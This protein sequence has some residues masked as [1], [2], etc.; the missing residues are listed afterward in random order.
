M[1]VFNSPLELLGTDK[2]LSVHIL[3][4]EEIGGFGDFVAWANGMRKF[5]TVGQWHDHCNERAAVLQNPVAA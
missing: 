1:N 4:V 3:P 5:D 2:R